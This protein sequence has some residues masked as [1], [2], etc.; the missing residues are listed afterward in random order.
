[1][2]TVA[3]IGTGIA[4]LTAAHVLRE[5]EHEVHV[6]EK[7]KRPGGAIRSERQDGFLVEHG[8]NTVRSSTLLDRLIAEYGLAE[9]RLTPT[10]AAGRRYVVRDGRLVPVPSSLREAITT[11]L[12][13]A[14]GKLRLL[15]EPFQPKA[16]ASDESVA[17]FVRR[18]LGPE[19]LR[20]AVDPFVAG[21]FAGDPEALSVRHAF[22]QLWR[23]EQEHGSLLMGALRSRSS[24]DTDEDSRSIFSLRGGLQ[25]LPNAMVQSMEGRVHLEAP[26]RSLRP[27]GEG[28]RVEHG[29]AGGAPN[30]FEAAVFAAP[31]HAL[32]DSIDLDVSADPSPIRNVRYPPM[33]V[34]ALGFRR[35]DV[36]HPLDGF[37][38]LVPSAEDDVRILG[39][40]FSSVIFGNRAPA[41]HV[42]LTV[43]LGG[44]R[45]PDSFKLGDAALVQR[46]RSDLERLLGV[47]AAPAF[48]RRIDWPNAIPQYEPGYERVK[49]RLRDLEG[50]HPRLAWAGNYRSGVSVSDAA[51]SGERAARR[52]LRRL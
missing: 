22:P 44:A 14:R 10:D 31:L 46:A 5:A 26:V 32:G 48:T 7:K 12:L 39:A 20:Y 13:S 41:G 42:L 4:G 21:V 24:S 36:A 43:F 45:H 8:P 29:S 49:Q 25:A 37:G 19:V 18:R 15:A 52:L 27:T 16:R 11:P 30:R 9:K 6:F 2:P 50:E 34:L 38:V 33:T 47:R 1:M 28:W 17:A 3:V 51:A 23:L 40:V 35:E